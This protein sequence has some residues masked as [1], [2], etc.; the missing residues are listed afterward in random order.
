MNLGLAKCCK[1]SILKS[2]NF[3]ATNNHYFIKNNGTYFALSKTHC[4]LLCVLVT[5]SQCY[6]LNICVPQQFLHCDSV[7]RVIVLGTG[8]FERYLGDKVPHNRMSTLRQQESAAPLSAVVGGP[9]N[10]AICNLEK[11]PCRSAPTWAPDVTKSGA[12]LL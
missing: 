10:T 12:F 5:I 2:N 11:S 1:L 6:E 7:L 3:R 8:A 4:I 9:Q